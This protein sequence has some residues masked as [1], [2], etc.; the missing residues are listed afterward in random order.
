MR[1]YIH[2]ATNLNLYY[3]RHILYSEQLDDN[4][5]TIESG[6]YFEHLGIVEFELENGIM[7]N[8]SQRWVDTSLDVSRKIIF[9]H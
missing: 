9:Y 1:I 4:A 7:S 3:Y 8:Y 2:L 5:Y 6:R